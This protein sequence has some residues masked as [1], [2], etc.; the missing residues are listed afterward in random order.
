MQLVDRVFRH[1]L[2]LLGQVV[3]HMLQYHHLCKAQPRA[4]PCYLV[5]APASYSCRSDI[6]NSTNPTL[7][8]IVVTILFLA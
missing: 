4:V 3:K 1:I 5:L 2:L 6:L 7:L 8:I